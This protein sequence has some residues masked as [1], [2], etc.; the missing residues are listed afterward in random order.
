M[1]SLKNTKIEEKDIETDYGKRFEPEIFT[2]GE[3]IEMLQVRGLIAQEYGGYTLTEK[4]FKI[5]KGVERSEDE[6]VAYGH[7][8]ITATHE[9]TIEITKDEK[10]GKKGSCIIGI[11]A[12]KGCKNLK[13]KLKNGLRECNRI[14]ITI[15]ADG[16]KDSLRAFGSPALTLTHPK[17]IV[18][19]KS[20]F[21]DDRT[22]AILADKAACDLKKELVE[23]LKNPKTKIK[24][25][26]KIG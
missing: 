8:N 14:T 12:N 19:R 15:E 22:V 26:F 20:D 4:G 24:V 11:K 3:V 23:K 9:T 7:P 13:R 16:V 5:L 25:K 10:L 6:V 21:I 2:Q 18:V 1:V 17:D